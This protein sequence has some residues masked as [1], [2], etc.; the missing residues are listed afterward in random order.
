M[1]YAIDVFERFIKFHKITCLEMEEWSEF[2]QSMR[3]RIIKGTGAAHSW[4]RNDM[5]WYSL[6]SDGLSPGLRKVLILGKVYLV[7]DE[8]WQQLKMLHKPLEVA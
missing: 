8:Q 6:C 1:I 7:D 4:R 2:L 5:Y 3:R